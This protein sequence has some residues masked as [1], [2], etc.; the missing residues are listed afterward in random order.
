VAACTS[1]EP[2]T[3]FEEADFLRLEHTIHIQE[4]EDQFIG[5]IRSMSVKTDP[6]R[7]YVADREMHRVAVVDSAGY[8]IQTIGSPGEGPGELLAPM[9]AVVWGDSIVVQNTRSELDVFHK[10]GSFVRRGRL[11]A[12]TWMGGPWSLVTHD[13]TL[14]MAVT[15]VDF[16]EHG[17]ILPADLPAAA[18]LN[19][20]FTLGATF[21]HFPPLYQEAEYTRQW[22]T[23]DV[24]PGGLAAM[25]FALV[26]HVYIV[27]LKSENDRNQQ[28]V[29]LDHPKFLHPPEP[30]PM[31]LSRERILELAP[32]FSNVQHTFI[33]SDHTVVQTFAHGTEAFYEDPTRPQEE[34]LTFASFGHVDHDETAFIRLPGQILAR[35]DNDRLYVEL[36]HRPDERK[37][38]VYEVNWP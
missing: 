12:G 4:D 21:G 26:P 17:V 9:R 7:L 23:L 19:W 28:I 18:C 16:R 10:N 1:E 11:P 24:S 14:C 3:R 5:V 13:S 25:G 27:D 20:D 36:N 34:Y 35:D 30:M 31:G 37:I 15:L 8:I 29:Q 38:G 32:Q 22:T 33:L 2:F 6:L